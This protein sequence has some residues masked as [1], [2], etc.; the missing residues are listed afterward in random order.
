MLKEDLVTFKCFCTCDGCMYML[1]IGSTSTYMCNRKKILLFILKLFEIIWTVWDCT[2]FVLWQWLLI[3]VVLH[4]VG[5][6]LAALLQYVHG[7][8]RL[9]SQYVLKWHLN[10]PCTTLWCQMS[11]NNP[12][13]QSHF[14]PFIC[15]E[16]KECLL[17]EIYSKSDNENAWAIVTAKKSSEWG[18]I[19]G[20]AIKQS[21]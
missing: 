18:C 10:Y 12:L 20:W 17:W 16:T 2:H 13:R 21:L 11:S 7:Y 3:T 9:C 8:S 4:V 19:D 6:S 15:L 5:W 14:L 1:E